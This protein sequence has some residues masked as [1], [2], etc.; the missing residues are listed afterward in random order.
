MVWAPPCQLVKFHDT[1]LLFSVC[2]TLCKLFFEIFHTLP[3]ESLVS[4]EP[5][6]VY[7]CS[8]NQDISNMFINFD[9]L[10]TSVLG[11]LFRTCTTSLL[12]LNVV[13]THSFIHYLCYDVTHLL[14]ISITNFEKHSGMNLRFLIDFYDLFI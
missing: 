14:H 6:N 11:T 3:F 12:R 9:L 8:I 13:L 1:H 2:V 10:G 4:I 5:L 7:P